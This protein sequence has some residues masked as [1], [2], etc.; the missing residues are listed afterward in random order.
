MSANQNFSYSYQNQI[1]DLGPLLAMIIKNAPTFLSLVP[2][3]DMAA[4]NPKHE[5]L[6]DYLKPKQ[7]T[8]ADTATNVAT[9]VDV[10]T[11]AIFKVGDVWVNTRTDERFRVDGVAAPT[12]TIVRGVG[13]AGTAMLSGDIL[14]LVARPQD[15][16]TDPGEDKGY[17]PT[18][19]FNHT[20][21]F[22]RTAKVTRT[23]LNTEQYGI[24]DLMDREVKIQADDITREMNMTFI[25]GAKQA[26]TGTTAATKGRAGGLYE[27]LDQAGAQRID[28]AGGALTKTMLNDALEKAFLNGAGQLVA[29][30]GTKQARAIT[31]LDANYEIVRQDTTSGKRILEYAGDMAGNNS[32]PARIVV[33][34]NYSNK[35][36]DLVDISRVSIVPLQ[37]SLLK[38]EDATPPGADYAARR[39]LGE[40]TFAMKNA[41]EAHA[42]VYN[43]A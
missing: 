32:T 38:D 31:A 16:G 19:A 43:L 33:D 30:C 9:T 21:I 29:L 25:W 34:P 11:A 17:E 37:N 41:K 40:Y 23:A 24:D 18:I 3:S 15:E 4:K 39:L 20:Q 14:R 28:G 7:D 2:I 27:F 10:T 35:R 13:G 36:I 5:W 42:S 8:T 6:E 1:R 12:L 26:R 22:D